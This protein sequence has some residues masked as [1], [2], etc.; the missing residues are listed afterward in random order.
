MLS[1]QVVMNNCDAFDSLK[2]LKSIW[3]INTIAYP[4]AHI[5]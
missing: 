5:E 1:T 2:M 3:N 4:K